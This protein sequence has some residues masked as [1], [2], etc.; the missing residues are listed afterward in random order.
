MQDYQRAFVDFL[1]EAEALQVGEFRLKSGRLSPIFLNTG[2]LDTGARLM[3]LGEAYAATALER[4]GADAFDVVFGP[5]YKGIP[6]A[7]AT[8]LALAAKGVDKPFLSDRKEAKDHGAEAGGGVEKM[9]LGRAPVPASRFL[10]VDD[11]QTTGGTKVEAVDLLRRVCKDAAFPGLLIVLDRQEQGADGRDAVG[12]FE[13]QTGIPVLPVLRVTEALDHLGDRGLLTTAL[14]D[15]C[16]AY[17][18]QHGT[19]DARAWAGGARV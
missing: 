18:S 6:L 16:R 14:R 3:R 7:V 1:L 13:A 5:A 17:W 12:A 2:R 15:R 4:I 19:E 11:V 10:L 9:L 8:V